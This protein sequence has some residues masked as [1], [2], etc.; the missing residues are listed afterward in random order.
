MPRFSSTSISFRALLLAVA[1]L[2]L[3]AAAFAAGRESQRSSVVIPFT[4]CSTETEAAFP[5]ETPYLA[6]NDAAMNKMMSSAMVIRPTGDVDR[7]FISM[8]KPHHQAAEG[9]A[10][11]FGRIAQMQLK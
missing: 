9:H 1:V 3:G 11:K 4:I 2:A 5:A 8:M 10:E 6:E 7:D